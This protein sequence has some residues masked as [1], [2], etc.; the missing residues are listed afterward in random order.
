[1][2]RKS[3]THVIVGRPNAGA[4][5]GAGGGLAARKLQQEI[6]RGGWKGV[7][8]VGVEWYAFSLSFFAFVC[9]YVCLWTIHSNRFFCRVLESIKAERRLS[10][11]RFAVVHVAAKGQRSVRGMFG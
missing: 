4:G 2:A 10:E 1:M 3:V 7:K 6:A 5:L 11:S 9:A 8:I